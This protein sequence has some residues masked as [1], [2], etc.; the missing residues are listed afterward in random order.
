MTELDLMQQ[1]ALK[2]RLGD[3]KEDLPLFEDY[4]T[5]YRIGANHELIGTEEGSM[6][7]YTDHL[8]CGGECLRYADMDGMAI[9]SRNA[10]IIHHPSVEGHLEVKSGIGFNALKYLY[11]Y[12]L[13]LDK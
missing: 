11:V 2:D 10:M 4:V 9:Y 13:K 1:Q 5:I 7:A 8:E 6:K 3:W 12:N